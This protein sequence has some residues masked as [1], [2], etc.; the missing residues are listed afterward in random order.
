MMLMENQTTSNR[1]RLEI[2][3]PINPVPASRPRVTRWGVYYGKKYTQWRKDAEEH[4]ASNPPTKDIMFTGPVEI[5]VNHV[6]IKPRTSKLEYPNPDIDNYNKA[7]YDAIT[8]Y[9]N[10]WT[11]D[12]LIVREHGQK[13]FQSEE[14][15]FGTHILIGEYNHKQ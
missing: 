9:T 13:N 10:V 11:D 1:P 8:S 15:K 3:I 6:V 12:K 14:L 7:V 2:Y 5:W 4:L